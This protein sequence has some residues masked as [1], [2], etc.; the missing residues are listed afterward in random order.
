MRLSG[1]QQ[2]LV[3]DPAPMGQL[4]WH[5]SEKMTF[6]A[7]LRHSKRRSL[8]LGRMNR[9]SIIVWGDFIYCPAEKQEAES[10]WRRLQCEAMKCFEKKRNVRSRRSISIQCV[11]LVTQRPVAL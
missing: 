4:G 1:L 3:Y 11:N 10:T 7:R 8:S 5:S 6:R 9:S 2:W